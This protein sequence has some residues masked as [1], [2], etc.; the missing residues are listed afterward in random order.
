MVTITWAFIR[1]LEN[2]LCVDLDQLMCIVLY[3]QHSTQYWAYADFQTLYY[4]SHFYKLLLSTRG[5]STWPT[6]SLYSSR[7]TVQGAM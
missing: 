3:E 4:H 5:Q 1:F 6:M 2:N 7:H